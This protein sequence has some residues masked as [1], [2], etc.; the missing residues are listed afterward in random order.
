MT[1]LGKRWQRQEDLPISECYTARLHQA[2][3]LL[4]D[5]VVADVK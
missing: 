2:S 4:R 1:M 3:K 5:S